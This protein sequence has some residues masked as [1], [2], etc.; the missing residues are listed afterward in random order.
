[1]E[2]FPMEIVL[3][4][5]GR[6]KL[7]QWSWI[8][9]RKLADWIRAYDEAGVFVENI[10]ESSREKAI[11]SGWIVSSPLLRCLQSAKALAPLQTINSEEVCREAGLPHAMWGFPWL[12]PSV[13]IVLFRAA[14][15]CGYSANSESLGLT[16]S[17]AQSAATKLIELAR[18]HQSVFVMGHGIMTALTAKELVMQGWVGP[19]RPAHGYWQ[20][21]VYQRDE[22]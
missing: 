2:V 13:W 19:R 5:H 12:P 20:F 17:R 21:S 11:R 1:M 6:P 16:K 4:R 18:A 3:A 15:F 7:K 22:Q 10:P 9:P 8:T 14:W